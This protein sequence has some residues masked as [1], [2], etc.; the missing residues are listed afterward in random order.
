MMARLL[1]ETKL[2]VW[3]LALRGTH[4]NIARHILSL[5]SHNNQVD[6]EDTLKG[7]PRP[8]SEVMDAQKSIMAVVMKLKEKGE[9]VLSK[10]K[11]GQL[12]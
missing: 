11:S 4:P 6:I 3:G 5:V 2:D 8:L 9:I 7:P 12:V 10:D 1:Q